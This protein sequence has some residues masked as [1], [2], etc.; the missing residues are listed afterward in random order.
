MSS[1]LFIKGERILKMTDINFAHLHVHT[2]YSLLD[3]STRVKELIKQTKKLN[4]DSVAITDHGSMFGI[5]EFYKTAKKEGINPI[6][7]SEIYVAI[8][9]HTEREPK[10]KRQYHLVLLAENN[11]GYKN[12]M[13]IVSKA[14]VDGFYYK[15]RA[16]KDIL[17]KYSKG[18]I[19]L[20]ACLGGEVQQHLL[21]NNYEL[22][23]KSALEYEEI[24]GKGNFF[25][26][27]QN[28]GI[29]EQIKVNEQL[30]K[31]SKELDIPL[32]ATN[33]V[34]Y[35]E[36]DDAISHDVLLCIQT[37]RTVNEENRMKFPSNQFYLKSP[38]EM[39][40]LFNFIPEAISNTQEIANRC[41]VDLDFDTLHL[42]EYTVPEGYTNETYLEELTISGLK[43]KYGQLSDE[44]IERYNYEMDTIKN[45]GYVDYFL[46]VWDFIR[47]ANEN[48]IM[49]GPGRGSAAGSIVSYGLSI[50]GIDPLK[51]GLIFERFLNPERVTMP[52]IDIDF[53]YERREEVIKYVIDKY[54]DARVAQIVTFG[55]MAARGAIR[56]VGRALDMPYNQ[57]DVIAKEIPTELGMTIDKALKVS[58]SLL[59]KYE[60]DIEVKRLIDLARSVEGLPRHTSTHAAGVVISKED[61]TEYVPLIRNNDAITT[62]FD[63]TELE[64]LGLLKMDVRIVRC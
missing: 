48:N 45:M 43:E 19:C 5:V 53:C 42:P 64:E 39:Y 54:G 6:L 27:L 10:D 52:D 55:T 57:V 62:Q 51:Y 47:Y 24:F 12:L 11:E 3:G 16:D 29:N 1:L 34:H 50:T 41:K 28:H 30:I 18:L 14:Y 58:K 49:V 20:S 8:N 35:L 44:V 40:D 2:E 56:D 23:K 22:A 7:G 59:A 15:P 17:K 37:G 9:K 13:K 60:E 63:M 36:K 38:K 31:L 46:I 25:L 26:E 4:M 61:I 33:D 32:V 21:D